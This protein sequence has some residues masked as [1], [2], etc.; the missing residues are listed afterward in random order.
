MRRPRAAGPESQAHLRDL[1]RR[2]EQLL[3][4]NSI[5]VPSPFDRH[6]LAAAIARHRQRPVTLRDLPASSRSGQHSGLWVHT[7]TQ[8]LIFVDPTRSSWEQDHITAHEVGHM[9]WG[10][11]A[12]DVDLG[13]ILLPDL[14]MTV[15]RAML[16]RHDFTSDQEREAEMMATVIIDRAGRA[17]P[18]APAGLSQVASALALDDV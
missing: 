7:A 11:E 2:C 9:L 18:G 3:D 14:D 1:R 10:H 15:V 12:S 6:G 16:G 5:V 4:D 13:E 8:D 17:A